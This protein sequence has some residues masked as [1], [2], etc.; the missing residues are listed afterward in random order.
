MT[1]NKNKYKVE[2]EIT[3]FYV[4]DVT[5]ENEEK[6]KEIAIKEFNDIKNRSVE[7]YYEAQDPNQ[8]ISTVYDVTNT[9]DPFSPVN[10]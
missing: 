3:S 10:K 2:F 7:H 5:A 1:T 9:D 4:V 8:T 6:A